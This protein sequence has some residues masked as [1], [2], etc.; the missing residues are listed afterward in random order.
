MQVATLDVYPSDAIV[1]VDETGHHKLRDPA[2]PVFGLAGCVM[3]VAQYRDVVSLA[4]RALKRDR[5]PRL[6]GVHASE[7]RDRGM[8]VQLIREQPF[9]RF[10]AVM[11]RDNAR[12]CEDVPGPDAPRACST[13][14]A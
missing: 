9:G 12:T 11:R 4:W 8:F 6:D 2:H 5:Y 7:L 1:F 13:A 3:T 10:A 14:V